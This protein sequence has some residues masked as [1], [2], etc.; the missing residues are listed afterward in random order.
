M[1]VLCNKCINVN[2]RR[3]VSN[4]IRKILNRCLFIE[5]IDG[6]VICNKCRYKYLIK[7]KLLEV[8]LFLFLI[9]SFDRKK[10]VINV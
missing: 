10:R 7:Y 8:L 4:D 3:I 6:K 1:C 5:S 2:V 9:Y